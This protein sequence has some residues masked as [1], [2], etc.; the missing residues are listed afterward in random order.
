[1]MQLIRKRRGTSLESNQV[2]YE[3]NEQTKNKFRKNYGNFDIHIHIYIYM[4]IYIYIY[5]YKIYFE[6]Q[7]YDTTPSCLFGRT[8]KLIR[9]NKNISPLHHYNYLVDIIEST[10]NRNQHKISNSGSFIS[11]TKTWLIYSD[12][13]KVSY[14]LPIL[15]HWQASTKQL[16]LFCSSQAINIT[17]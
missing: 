14:V 2:K 9:H 13:I 8:N 6:L 5:I 4:C 15:S 17:E 11:V 16:M 1:M 3:P 7:P 10:I 12:Q